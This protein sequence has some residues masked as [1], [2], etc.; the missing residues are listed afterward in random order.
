MLNYTD[1]KK[2]VQFILEGQPYEVLESGQMK[3]AQ[4]RPVMQT[5]IRNLITGNVF[6][7]NFQQGETF[8]EAELNKF[9]A[10]FLYAHRGR[11]FF[12]EEGNPSKRFD[13]SE[14]QI[15]QSVKFLKQN[16]VVEAVTF[17]GK[18][19]NISLPIKVQ[20]KIK[21]AP[22]GIKGDRAQGGTKTAVLET[23]ARI[24]VPLFVEAGDVI[25]INTEKG[26]YVRRI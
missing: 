25:E 26:E 5:K 16:Q 13:L 14:E 8:K 19:I 7:R 6:E 9:K 15:G 20:M 24:Q 12:C 17:E 3:K 2:G 11:Y 18:I 21:E 22:P 4:R 23:G 1:L 10:K